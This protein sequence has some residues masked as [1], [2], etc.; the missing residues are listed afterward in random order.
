[1]DSKEHLR[2]L[3]NVL[4]FV[5]ASGLI[6]NAFFIFGL[7]FHE[8]LLTQLGI[9]QV[10][11]ELDWEYAGLWTYAATRSMGY[12]LVN[13]WTDYVANFLLFIA[14]IGFIAI[15]LWGW[16]DPKSKEQKA[17]R[18]IF[19]KKSRDFVLRL[20]K[21]RIL[22]RLPFKIFNFLFVK[23]NG[24]KAFLNSY[25]LILFTTFIPLFFLVWSV[26]PLWGVEYGQKIA[27]KRLIQYQVNLCSNNLIGSDRCISISTDHIK[28]PLLPKKISGRLVAM[29]DKYLGIITEC[30]ALTISQ[31]EAFWF[32]D[33][34][35]FDEKTVRKL[36]VGIDKQECLS[37]LRSSETKAHLS[38]AN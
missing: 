34:Y 20:K 29:S 1:M 32:L 33:S 28:D 25:L 30:G 2:T 17:E 38:E 35:N 27:N 9:Q 10:Y 19:S 24:T 3:K 7:A 13:F 21:N 23:G 15:R 6:G 26:F 37:S 12:D 4:A 11:F 36:K 18:K 31:P 14:P 16:L 5:L 8:G 22:L